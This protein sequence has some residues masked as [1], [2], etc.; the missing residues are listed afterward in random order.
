MGRFCKKVLRLPPRPVNVAAKYELRR[1]CRRRRMCSG[2]ANS[3][4][5]SYRW[6][7]QN[8]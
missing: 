6:N 8:C 7:K 5:G 4:A 2:I 3:G 1:E